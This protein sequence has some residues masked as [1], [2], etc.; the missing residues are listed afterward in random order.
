MPK[1]KRA[2][3]FW[4]EKFEAFRAQ[5]IE[6]QTDIIALRHDLEVAEHERDE[7]LK[8]LKQWRRAH[9]Q[10]VENPPGATGKYV[11]VMGEMAVLFAVQLPVELCREPVVCDDPAV[12]AALQAVSD[13]L[14]VYVWGTDKKP[15]VVYCD[16]CDQ[17]VEIESD[18]RE[19]L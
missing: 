5:D 13:H 12:E 18:D 1:N 11:D 8:E 16:V 4:A 7:A 15:A 6:R 2:K 9:S 17:N 10:P 19:V 3:K 14:D